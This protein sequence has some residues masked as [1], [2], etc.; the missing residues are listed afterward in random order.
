MYD[1]VQLSFYAVHRIYRQTDRQCVDIAYCSVYVL[2]SCA[3]LEGEVETHTQWQA[4]IGGWWLTWREIE[5]GG[6]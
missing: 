4:A 3:I 5:E 6:K 2:R 1:I